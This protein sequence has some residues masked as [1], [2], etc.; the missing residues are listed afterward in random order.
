MTRKQKIEAGKWWQVYPDDS[1]DCILFEGSKACCQQFIRTYCP[2]A[3]KQGK[4]R[5]AKLIY[6][7]DKIT[8]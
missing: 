4:V 6:E 7:S 1:K 2:Y 3:F 8:N 5:L